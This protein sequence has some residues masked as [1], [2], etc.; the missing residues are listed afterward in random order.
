MKFDILNHTKFAPRGSCCIAAAIIGAG[1][2]SAGA[3]AFGASKAAKAQEKAGQAAIGAQKEMFD[4]TRQTLSPFI[5]AGEGAIPGLQEWLATDSNNPLSTILKLITPGPN[6][7]A[8]LE[9]LPGF[10]FTRDTGL[11]AVNNALAARGLGGSGGA[12]A[13]GAADYVTGL[14]SNTWNNLITQLLNTFQSGG[15]ALQNLVNTGAGAGASLGGAS[16]AT[17]QQI[18]NTLVGIG[19]AQAAGFNA[20]GSAGAGFANTIGSGALINKLLGG[21]GGSGTGLYTNDL[22]RP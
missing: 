15:S 17:G 11:K 19:N 18:G 1:A 22:I 2:L 21:S 16:T 9:Q 6:Q 10:S 7:S 8:T 20:L 3:T 14:S 5:G 12:V 4:I 13:R